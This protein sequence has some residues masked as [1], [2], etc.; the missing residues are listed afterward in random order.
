MSQNKKYLLAFIL[1]LIIL[2]PLGLVAQGPAWGEWSVEEIRA[3]IGFVPQS[4]ENTKPL[5]GAI[6]PDYEISGLSPIAST[7]ISA[8][9][10]AL[11]V[12]AVMVGI[13]KSVKRES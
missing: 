2:T 5:I 10:G 13:K 8:V 4:I 1:V 9:V 6:I 11:L 12:F 3:M 7:W